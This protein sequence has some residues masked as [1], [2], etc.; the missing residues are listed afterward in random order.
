[1]LISSKSDE[2]LIAEAHTFGVDNI[3][4]KPFTG[5]G[6]MAMAEKVIYE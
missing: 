4:K 1:M 6:L 3:L 5:N 2:N